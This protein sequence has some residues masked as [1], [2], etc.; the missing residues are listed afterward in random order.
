MSEPVAAL[1][2]GINVGGRSTLSMA[3][4]RS[5]LSASGFPDARTYLQSGN[6][7]LTA[8]SEDTRQL[9]GALEQIIQDR[10]GLSV[11]VVIRTRAELEDVI[12]RNPYLEPGMPPTSLHVIFLESAPDGAKVTDLDPGR[13]PTDRFTV[14]EREIFLH[15]P[16]G[17]GR[18]KLNLDYFERMLGVRGTA[19]NWNTVGKLAGMLGG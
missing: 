16:Q 19:R 14:S 8:D 7:V 9:A 11:R 3:G 18:S 17:S 15:Y 12:G 2:R 4:L 10:F 13:S 5:A 1:I 6:L